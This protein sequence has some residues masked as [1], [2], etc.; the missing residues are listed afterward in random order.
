M[1]Q[2]TYFHNL[3]MFWHFYKQ[4]SKVSMFRWYSSVCLAGQNQPVFDIWFELWPDG[5]LYCNCQFPQTCDP[6]RLCSI[7]MRIAYSR[8]FITTRQLWITLVQQS[9][10][11]NFEYKETKLHSQDQSCSCPTTFKNK[12]NLDIEAVGINPPILRYVTSMI[13]Q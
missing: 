6:W 7:R 2:V 11:Y 1:Y 12:I 8:L 4:S 3:V 13:E 5:T 10:K 9:P